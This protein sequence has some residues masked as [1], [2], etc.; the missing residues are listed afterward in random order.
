MSDTGDEKFVLGILRFFEFA[1][2]ASL[3]GVCAWLHDR[4]ADARYYNLYRIDVTLGFSVAATFISALAALTYIFHSAGTQSVMGIFDVV[5]FAGYIASAVVFSGFS[6]KCSSNRFVVVIQT[7]GS[8]SCGTVRL[9][10]AGIIIQ[11]LLFLCTAILS[12][13]LAE[14]L[15]RRRAAEV[16]PSSQAHEQKRWYGRK[17]SNPD[18]VRA[19]APAEA[20]AV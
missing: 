9:A 4:L 20:P 15:H 16:V 2:G 12:F 1:F 5:L 13:H 10:A 11:I 14:R 6:A 3:V 8:T 18:D 17:R 19:E 7:V